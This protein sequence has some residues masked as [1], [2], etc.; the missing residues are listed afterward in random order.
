MKLPNDFAKYYNDLKVP[1]PALEQFA[2]MDFKFTLG[3][4]LDYFT[5]RGIV[6]VVTT[7]GFKIRKY[8]LPEPIPNDYWLL[9]EVFENEVDII[10]SYS[11]AIQAAIGYLENPF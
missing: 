1:K 6:V 3:I 5:S 11:K 4:Y 8:P 7:I 10:T 9:E 2:K